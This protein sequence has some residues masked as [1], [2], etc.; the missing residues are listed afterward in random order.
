MSS[1]ACGEDGNADNGEGGSLEMCTLGWKGVSR[2]GDNGGSDD[3]LLYDMPVHSFTI[4]SYYK[5]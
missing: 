3:D 2:I 5:D 4:T 1:S